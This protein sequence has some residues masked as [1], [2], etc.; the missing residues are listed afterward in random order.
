MYSSAHMGFTLQITYFSGMHLFI[1]ASTSNDILL[2]VLTVP[3]FCFKISCVHSS[4][5]LLLFFY[6]FSSMNIFCV[7][8]YVS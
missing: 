8:F 7:D 2:F 1:S 3:K 4:F 5:F 6:N